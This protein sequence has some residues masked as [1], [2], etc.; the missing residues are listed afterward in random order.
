[1]SVRYKVLVVDDDA[2]MRAVLEDVLGEAGYSV[3]SASALDE[4]YQLLSNRAFDVVV[5]DLRFREGNASGMDLLAW[6]RDNAATTPSIMITGHASVE[7]AIE[8]MKLGAFDYVMKPF[9][10]DEIRMAV[11]RAIDQR[12]LLRENAALRKDQF[13]REKVKASAAKAP[14]TQK[15]AGRILVMDDETS[16]RELLEIILCNAGYTVVSAANMEKAHESL[17]EDTFDVAIT[18]LRMGNERTAGMGLLGWLRENAPMTPAIMI[19]AHGS[20]ETAI[21]AMK[22][23]AFDYIMK[24]FKNDEMRLLVKRAIEHGMLLRE[25][26]EL[27]KD[28]ESVGKIDNILGKSAAIQGVIDMIRRVATLPSTVAIHGESGTGKE[29]VARAIHQ[30]SDRA[31]KPF[32]AINC[33]GIPENLLE[34]ELFGHKKGSFTGAIEDKEGLFVVADGGT[35]FLDEIGEM[36]MALQVKLLRVLDNSSVMPVGGVAEI[37]VNV[38]IISATNR[39]LEEMVKQGRFRTDLYYRLNVIPIHVPP[40][41]ERA[42]DIPLLARYFVEGHAGRMGRTVHEISPEAMEALCAFNWTGNVRELENAL[43]RAVALCNSARIELT[44]LPRNVQTHLAMPKSITTELPSGGVDLE[45]LVADLEISLIKQALQQSK[46][47]QKRAA[48]LLGLTP[49][50]LRYRLQKYGL[51]DE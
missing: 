10:N 41:R 38:R 13:A 16:M 51:G 1:M 33:G 43:E 40:L 7:N 2:G 39:N 14:K 47:S 29:L 27:L 18:D 12:N 5:T 17:R 49:R 44:D 8:A 20:I 46:Y 3:N 24:P 6:L 26:A 50:T 11:K 19:T 15:T 35:L 42:D 9:T 45:A 34:S 48:D 32:V 36:P 23:G 31:D 30:L 37:A 4:A 21:E 25:N 22:L 28:Q